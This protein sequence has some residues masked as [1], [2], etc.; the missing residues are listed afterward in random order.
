MRACVRVRWR[1][2]EQLGLVQTRA[3]GELQSD[4]EEPVRMWS[5]VVILLLQL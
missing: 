5:P 1:E 3:V 4:Q 2:C